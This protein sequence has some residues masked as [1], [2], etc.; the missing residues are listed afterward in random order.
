[1]N[2]CEN[3]QIMQPTPNVNH[4]GGLASR[5]NG[6]SIILSVSFITVN[7]S[8]VDISLAEVTLTGRGTQ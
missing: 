5:I 2:S 3:V 1:M 7:D 4:I 8:D 6:P